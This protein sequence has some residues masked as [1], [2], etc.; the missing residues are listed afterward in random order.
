MLHIHVGIKQL[1]LDIVNYWEVKED[2]EVKVL[3]ISAV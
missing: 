3:E 1:L 2:L